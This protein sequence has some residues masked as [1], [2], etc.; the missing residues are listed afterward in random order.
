VSLTESEGEE[1]VSWSEKCAWTWNAL[2]S[3]LVSM[4]AEPSASLARRRPWT[5]VV[6]PPVVALSALGV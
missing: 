6:Q 5:E 4:E 3:A 1:V 2:E